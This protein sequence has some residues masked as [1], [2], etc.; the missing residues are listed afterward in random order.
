[1]SEKQKGAI[2]CSHEGKWEEEL[3]ERLQ[4]DEK[5][6][7]LAIGRVKYKL[8]AYLQRRKD[9]EVVKVETKYMKNRDKGI[10]LKV[11]VRRLEKHKPTS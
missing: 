9:I 5:V 8:L 10:G 1:M 4:T 2:L 11:A 7:L 3:E 6:T